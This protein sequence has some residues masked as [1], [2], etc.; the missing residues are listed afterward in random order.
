METEYYS[1]IVYLKHNKEDRYVSRPYHRH[2]VLDLQREMQ[3]DKLVFIWLGGGSR[4]GVAVDDILNIV[5]VPYV[6]PEPPAV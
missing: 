3:K 1:I 4:L 6:E 5:I 2:H